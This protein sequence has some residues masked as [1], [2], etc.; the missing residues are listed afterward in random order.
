MTQKGPTL[1]L[2]AHLP[3]SMQCLAAV[4]KC[5]GPETT[6]H[7]WF[8]RQGF[9]STGCPRTRSVDQA[10]PEF[11]VLP[12]SA[13]SAGIKVC[14]TIANLFT[15]T[16]P[17]DSSALLQSRELA[18]FEAW[19]PPKRVSS[20]LPHGTLFQAVRTDDM[21]KAQ[22]CGDC[23]LVAAGSEWTVHEG[24]VTSHRLRML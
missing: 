16:R 10:V 13:S 2:A 19:R 6:Y 5:S 20:F 15:F 11:G 14:A 1:W 24:T 3:S 12:A 22:G 23:P 18:G 9:S 4:P 21:L 8:L 17:G 7:T